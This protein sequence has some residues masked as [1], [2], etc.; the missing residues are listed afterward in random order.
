MTLGPDVRVVQVARL[1]RLQVTIPWRAPL[2]GI[3]L[4]CPQ[5][6]EADAPA[7]AVGDSVAVVGGARVHARVDVRG[8]QCHERV[9]GG[10]LV[11]LDGERVV[12]D[13]CGFET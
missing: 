3:R 7:C 2:Q 12:S 10:V 1:R 4:V 11:A 8:E 9:A 13:H 6:D 5:R